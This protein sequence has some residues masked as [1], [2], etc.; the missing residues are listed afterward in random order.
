MS[1]AAPIFHAAGYSVE[2]AALYMGVMANNGVDAST[3]ANSLKTGMARLAK[4]AKEGAEMLDKLGI[5]VFNADGTMK[6]SV[7]VQKLLHDSFATL[8]E[9]EQIAA[10]SA[11]FGKNNM[12]SW[13]AL[14]NTAPKDVEE[15]AGSLHTAAGTTDEMSEAMM[16]GFGGSIEKL[17]S[18]IDVLMYTL[19]KLAAEY[20]APVI[21]KIQAAVDKFMS[22]DNR[23]KALIVRALGIAAAVGPIL[24]VGGKLMQGIGSILTFVPKLVGGIGSLIGALGPWGLAIAAAIAIGILLY[25][26]W[27]TIK[28]WAG[29]LAEAVRA[30]WE[31]M[32]Q[33][34]SEVWD[35]LKEKTSATMA[36][37]KETI[38]NKWESIKTGVTNK[39]DSIRDK[40]STTFENIKTKAENVW[41]SIKTGITSK[42]E[43]ARDAVRNAIDR[44]KS[45][46]NF[47]WS[48]PHIALPHFSISG[49]FS[50][51]PPS[52]PHFSVAWYKKAMDGGMILDNP[53]IF[54]MMNGQLLGGGEAGPEAVVG[55]QSL[56][57]MIQKAVS[58]VNTAAN[59]NYG[60]VTINVYGAEGQSI[61]DLADEIEE[62]INFG[63]ARKTAAWA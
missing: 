4:P 24:I 31:S 26:N 59:I 11:I 21:E 45:F 8:S 10:A 40:I 56:M 60:G 50:L 3:A 37:I 32:K 29:R 14:I 39:V 33:K 48:L 23:T 53:T 12:S 1:V 36:N 62:R 20:L 51:N 30:A 17:K 6:D 34:I 7:E 49:T 28:E 57:Q 2:D 27:D 25:Q 22:L 5:S 16:S 47:Q 18:S 41:E 46:F 43:A 52:I 42:I 55:T 19:G 13:L 61:K 38:S 44:M 9:Q 54:G 35:N 63:V 15:L 58:A